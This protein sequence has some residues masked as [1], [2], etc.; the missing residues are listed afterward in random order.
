[1]GKVRNS[2]YVTLVPQP[3]HG[4]V[5]TIDVRAKGT[6]TQMVSTLSLP[7]AERLLNLVYGH[8]QAIVKQLIAQLESGTSLELTAASPRDRLVFRRESLAYALS[9]ARA[10]RTQSASANGSRGLGCGMA[11]CEMLKQCGVPTPTR[12]A[13]PVCKSLART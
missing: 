10:P 13:G 9:N 8:E 2:S 6:E 1:M 11:R 7:E 12:V 5:A 3:E 4:V